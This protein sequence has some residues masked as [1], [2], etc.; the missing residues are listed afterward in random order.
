MRIFLAIDLPAGIKQAFEPIKDKLSVYSNSIR[1]TP[2]ENMHITVK[3]LGDQNLFAV[4]R[5]RNIAKY[6]FRNVKP[7]NICLNEFGLFGGIKNPRILWVGENNSDFVKLASTVN[8]ELELFYKDRKKPICHLTIGR[9][10]G[11][12]PKEA[13]AA[14]DTLKTFLNENKLCF[15]VAE[16]FLYKSELQR[17]GAVYE[18]IEKFKLEGV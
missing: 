14:L 2:N 4:D 8:D 13:V 15:S 3:F 18:K 1:I 7:F 6:I 12:K 11:L 5:V 10:K 16:L 17:S 9:I